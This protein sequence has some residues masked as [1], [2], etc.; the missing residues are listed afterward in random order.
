MIYP[1]IPDQVRTR[2]VKIHRLESEMFD[3]LE[4]H[5]HVGAGQLETATVMDRMLN[6]A[7]HHRRALRELASQFN[8]E[9][10]STTHVGGDATSPLELSDLLEAQA[11]AVATIIIA[12][13]AIFSCAR[14]PDKRAIG[15]LADAHAAEWIG[16][17]DELTDLIPVIV[18]RE[19]LEDGL[20][21]RCL[22]PA[23]GI[24]A[25]LCMPTSINT[26]RAYWRRPGLDPD[27]G[28]ELRIPPRTESQLAAAGLRQGDRVMA[29]DGTAIHTN[30]ELQQALQAHPLGELMNVRVL[31]AGQRKVIQVARVSDFPT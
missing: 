8:L 23:C 9:L 31:L 6:L 7:K 12:Y 4:T 21:C 16:L 28:L 5:Q 14:L 22:C 10:P 24:G 29:I 2:L 20:A 3:R 25:C 13:G 17:F 15:D 27:E 19:L 1:E 26:M 11:T 30:S 18:M